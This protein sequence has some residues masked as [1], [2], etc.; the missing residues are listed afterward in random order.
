MW[1]RE[2]KL[3]EILTHQKRKWIYLEP[4]HKFY[5]STTTYLPDFYLPEEG[6]Y[7]ELI[8]SPTSFHRVIKKIRLFKKEY[9]HIKIML[10]NEKGDKI[11]TK[12]CLKCGYIWMQQKT[13][14]KDCPKCTKDNALCKRCGYTWKAKIKKPKYCPCCYSKKIIRRK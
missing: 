5:L 13:F 3:S 11:K 1:P 14:R 9:P 6:L 4:R 10:V 2:K 12:K 8:G 7:L